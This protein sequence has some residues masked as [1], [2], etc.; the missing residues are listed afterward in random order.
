[1]VAVTPG[2][3]GCECAVG[4]N[5]AGAGTVPEL[6]HGIT[7]VAVFHVRIGPIAVG[8]AAC[9]I[10]FVGNVCP[11]RHFGVRRVATGACDGRVVWTGE[12]G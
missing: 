11:C 6:A 12:I 1:M 5:V 10:G 9:A 7:H 2:F 4:I 3:Y 8:M